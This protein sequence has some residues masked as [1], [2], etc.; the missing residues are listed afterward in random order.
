M[1]VRTSELAKATRD[2]AQAAGTEAQAVVDQGA[3]LLEQA[4]PPLTKARSMSEQTA[5][6]TEQLELTRRTVA[7]TEQSLRNSIQPWLTLGTA[8]AP[9]PWVPRGAPPWASSPHAISVQI[10]Q[11]GELQVRLLVRNVGVGLAIIDPKKSHVVGFKDSR[12]GD[13]QGLMEFNSGAVDL[14]VLPPREQA[15]VTWTVPLKKWNTDLKTIIGKA[16]GN[17]FGTLFLDV[18]YTD[19]AAHHPVRV[20]YSVVEEGGGGW[21]AWRVEHFDPANAESPEV[22][23]WFR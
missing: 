9:S 14:P 20:R 17:V 21:M 5:A 7:L 16:I 1:A 23:T 19:V 6:S 11:S 8:E 22:T 2:M 18:V 12:S 3:V 10:D 4:R 15:W 13:A